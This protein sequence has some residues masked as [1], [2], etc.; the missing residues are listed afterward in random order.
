MASS[1]SD[2]RPR[3]LSPFTLDP[4]ASQGQNISSEGAGGGAGAWLKWD[5]ARARTMGSDRWGAG[6]GKMRA[7]RPVGLDGGEKWMMMAKRGTQE[8]TRAA[9]RHAIA[10][11]IRGERWAQA[12]HVGI[13]PSGG[14]GGVTERRVAVAQTW[15]SKDVPRL[16]A[17]KTPGCSFG[18]GRYRAHTKATSACHPRYEWQ[19]R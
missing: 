15:A 9:D 10:R 8:G 18:I 11:A 7:R 5:P 19:H 2:H 3:P 17:T 12:R 16:L 13:V 1:D 4:G 14:A 6:D